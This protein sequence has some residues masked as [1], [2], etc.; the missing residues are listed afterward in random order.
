MATWNDLNSVFGDRF[1]NPAAAQ[2]RIQA[3]IAP[4]LSV[5]AGAEVLAN[6]VTADDVADVLRDHL[7]ALVRSHERSNDSSVVAALSALSEDF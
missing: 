2:S 4:V 3:A 5:K 6:D 1:P 7:L